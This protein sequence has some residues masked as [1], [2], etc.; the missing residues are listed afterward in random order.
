MKKIVVIISILSLALAGCSCLIDFGDPR[1]GSPELSDRSLGNASFRVDSDKT[2]FLKYTPSG[3]KKSLQVEDVSGFKWTLVL[4]DNAL[5]REENIVM[6]PLNGIKADNMPGATLYGISMEPDGLEFVLC[7]E[8]Y[9]EKSGEAVKGLILTAG[10]DGSGLVLCPVEGTDT[11]VKAPIEHFSTLFFIPESDPSIEELQEQAQEEYDEAANEA[12]EL[13][14]EEIDAPTPPSIS[15]ECPDDAKYAIAAEY[16]EEVAGEEEEL[17]GRLIA[18]GRSLYFLSEDGDSDFTLVNRLL[19]RMDQRILKIINDH[20]PDPEKLLAVFYAALRIWRQHSV[21]SDDAPPMSTLLN[22]A[23]SARTHYFE[24]L[25]NEHEYKSFSAAIELDRMCSAL[26]GSVILSQIIN[27]MAFKVTFEGTITDTD[28]DGKTVWR[29]EGEALVMYTQKE[30]GGIELRGSG[31]GIHSEYSTTDDVMIPFMVSSN[32]PFEVRMDLDPCERE[33]ASVAIDRFGAENLT[34]RDEDGIEYDVYS[35]FNGM[36]MYLEDFF[37]E[38]LDMF[39]AI[40][41]LEGGSD[42]FEVRMEGTY[43]TADVSYTIKITH[44]PQ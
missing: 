3:P 8:I 23:Q 27:S 34:Y 5:I 43:A 1:S 32:F 13:L 11:G 18:A 37:D 20:Q 17:A 26:G 31:S 36:D 24:R 40:F 10:H 33:S 9:I 42:E 30:L 15:L 4:P 14:E 28:D 2:V 7:P 38:D 29:T 39:K 6:T 12:A 35:V 44:E 19:D 25:R 21:L 41:E 16:A 22:W